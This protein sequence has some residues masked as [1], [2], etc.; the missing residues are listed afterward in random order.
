MSG[1]S[2][3]PSFKCRRACRE[4][5]VTK[6]IRVVNKRCRNSTSTL[7]VSMPAKRRRTQPGSAVN[8]ALAV[9]NK[10]PI[11]S[12]SDSGDV[13]VVSQAPSHPVCT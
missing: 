5:E 11:S 9:V 1:S 10:R 8:E 13:V 4:V 7:E 6:V 3:Q 12:L 2:S